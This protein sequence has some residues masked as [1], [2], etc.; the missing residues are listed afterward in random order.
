MS[1][2]KAE[3]MYWTCI[4]REPV[5]V[6]D[7]QDDSDAEFLASVTDQTVRWKYLQSQAS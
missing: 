1:L 6:S 2:L 3:V 7:L 4:N 5:K